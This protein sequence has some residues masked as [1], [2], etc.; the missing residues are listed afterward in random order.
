MYRYTSSCS[1]RGGICTYSSISLKVLNTIIEFPPP[2]A[3][4]TN[5][6]HETGDYSFTVL[7]ISMTG[8]KQCISNT[9]VQTK[10][11]IRKK[12]RRQW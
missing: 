7:I 2:S 1:S 8:L 9:K 10:D 3:L 6:N 4:L 5:I 11:D 12:Q